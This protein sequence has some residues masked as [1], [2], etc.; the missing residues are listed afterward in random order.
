MLY[1]MIIDN[2]VCKIC[3]LYDCFFMKMCL[4]YLVLSCIIVFYHP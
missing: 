2:I 3:M 4:H 1:V